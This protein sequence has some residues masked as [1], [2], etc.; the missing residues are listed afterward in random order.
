MTAFLLIW[1]LAALGASWYIFRWTHG[2]GDDVTVLDIMFFAFF[3]LL[4]GL[5]MIL[6]IYTFKTLRSVF[7][8]VVYRKRI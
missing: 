3:G 7:G 5:P 4:L 1:L 8:F 6:L 2:G